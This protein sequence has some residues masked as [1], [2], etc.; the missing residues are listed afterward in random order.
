MRSYPGFNSELLIYDIPDFNV[1]APVG[2]SLF[3]LWRERDFASRHEDSLK[4]K[5]FDS[6]AKLSLKERKP[7]FIEEPKPGPTHLICAVCQLQFVDYH[8]HITSDR[9]AQGVTAAS[10]LLEQVDDIIAELDQK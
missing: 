5:Y 6:I 9:H 10:S 3:Q 1:Q 8:A 7:D 2:T 4:Q